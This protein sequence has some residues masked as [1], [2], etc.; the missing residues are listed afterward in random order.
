MMANLV[1]STITSLDGYIADENGNV[2]WGAPDPEVLAFM[3][4][5]LRGFGTYLYGR[6][7]YE[8]M[9]YWESFD[10]VED[11]SLGIRE[12][13]EM[14]RATTKVVF[15]RSLEAVSSQRTRI[16]QAFDHEAVRRMKGDDRT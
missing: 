6:G 10:S 8:S 1:Y 16:E 14:W 4:D 3:N 13:A 9:V 15:S 2:D 5:L 11:Q 7:M 12:F